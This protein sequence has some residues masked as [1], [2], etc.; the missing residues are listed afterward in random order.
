MQNKIQATDRSRAIFNSLRKRKGVV[1]TQSYLRLEQTLGTSGNI[2]FQ[3]LIND[4][5]ANFNER[6]LAIT[7]AFTVTS[8]AVMIYKQ[9]SGGNISAGVLD[10]N[11]N[12]LVYTG[13]GEAAAL[14]A[15]YNGYLSVRVN[16]VVYIDS[17]DVYRFYR[18][19]TAQ[20]AVQTTVTPSVYTAS[21][22][23]RG[24]YPFYSLTPGIR[25]SG[26]T[27]NE[28]SLTLPESV[29]M[30]GTGGTVNRVVCYLRGFLEQNGA[31]FQP[32]R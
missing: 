25:L 11:P 10:T 18:V 23:E 1:T 27:K 24:D 19:G 22:Y 17:L 4:G 20:K 28:L 5:Q 7:D 31:Q 14:Q 12:P 26:A 32:A 15:L 21:A 8:L 30:A 13:A 3:V 2:N 9:A 29:A 6:R 16:S